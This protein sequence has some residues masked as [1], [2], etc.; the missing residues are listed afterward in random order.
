MVE[1]GGRDAWKAEARP[2]MVVQAKAKA[3]AEAAAAKEPRLSM[4][5]A[6]VLP[7]PSMHPRSAAAAALP[8]RPT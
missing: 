8:S 6:K 3:L 5:A 7:L 2:G 4:S 1:V